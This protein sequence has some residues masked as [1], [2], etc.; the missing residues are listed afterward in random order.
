M[1]H[2]PNT[3]TSWLVPKAAAS[4]ACCQ[5][6]GSC[7][8]GSRGRQ[9]GR[10]W[11]KGTGDSV[12][13]PTSLVP[14]PCPFSICTN[15]AW[16][17]EDEAGPPRVLI[18]GIWKLFFRSLRWA[19]SVTEP[20][21]RRWSILSSDG[22]R[23][24][25]GWSPLRRCLSFRTD[26]DDAQRTSVCLGYTWTR[27]IGVLPWARA[28]CTATR[29][30]TTARHGHHGMFWTGPCFCQLGDKDLGSMRSCIH[31]LVIRNA[32]RDKTNSSSSMQLTR[33]P[34]QWHHLLSHRGEPHRFTPVSKASLD[35]F[36]VPHS[37]QL[38][39]QNWIKTAI[40]HLQGYSLEQQ[41][42]NEQPFHYMWGLLSRENRSELE[43][44]KTHVASS[45]PE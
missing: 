11:P 23:W 44:G 39:R 17:K 29:N 35:C 21:E 26:R 6:A 36:L 4:R 3:H 24:S 8:G 42:P 25:L 15:K 34:G 32:G 5:Y 38:K 41:D 31:H 40:P 22:Q 43:R 28:S 45:N 7:S 2:E 13:F 16:R 33:W 14:H 27:D 10:G 30:P 19:P 20:V 1:Y 18:L 37:K 9:E 12:V